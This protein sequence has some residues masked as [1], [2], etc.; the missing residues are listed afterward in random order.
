MSA[1]LSFLGGVILFLLQFILILL[2]VLLGLGLLLLLC[3]FCAD[4]SWEDEVLRVRVGALG[5]TL[6]VFQYPQPEPPVTEEGEPP[7]PGFWARQWQKFRA[8]WT[9]R[10]RRRAAKKP[11][12]PAGTKPKTAPRKK[13]KITLDVVCALLRGAGQ[14]TRAAFGALRFTRIRVYLPVSGQDPADAA[15]AYGQ[16]NAW[17]YTT[18]GVLDHFV[19]LDFEE[20]RVVPQVDPAQ[21]PARERVSFRVSARLLFVAIATVRVLIELWREKVLDVF[22]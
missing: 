5:I 18:L 20:L 11:P 16:V 22:L 3:P 6:P 10:R 19:Y 2:A 14:I 13:A 1:F 21:P 12:K 15:R 4:L 8:W 9:E 7:E 17:L